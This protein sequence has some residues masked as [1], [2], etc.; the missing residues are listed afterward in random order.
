[1]NREASAAMPIRRVVVGVD[2]GHASLSAVAFGC[3][4]G[5]WLDLP[6]VVAHAYTE[7][8]GGPPTPLLGFGDPSLIAREVLDGALEHAE[9]AP[10]RPAEITSVLLRGDAVRGLVDQGR[11]DSILVIGRPHHAART[12]LPERSVAVRVLARATCPVAVVP[13][14]WRATG[15]TAVADPVTVGLDGTD[16][17][18]TLLTRALGLAAG[19]QHPLRVLHVAPPAS[20]LAAD[21]ADPEQ[22]RRELSAE[23]ARA[24]GTHP[25][26]VTSL[27]VR[28]GSPSIELERA[29]H[30]AAV[31][32][33][34]RHGT[35]HGPR[36][37]LGIVARQVLHT[38]ACPVLFDAVRAQAANAVG[39]K[40][41]SVDGPVLR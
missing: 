28:T 20:A 26:V 3:A 12:P 38:A 11:D 2:E 16:T 13:A 5:R 41:A 35:R 18:E 14:A 30:H 34:G 6:V 4:L 10:I 23:L 40:D 31:L 32:V 37:R 29:S 7:G 17:G 9:N 25:G 8:H 22:L 1:M 19:A 39:G 15:T 33:L 27:D 24:V 36:H 21:D